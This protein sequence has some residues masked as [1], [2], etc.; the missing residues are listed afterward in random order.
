MSNMSRHVTREAE[1]YVR[2]RMTN[3]VVIALEG[4]RYFEQTRSKRNGIGEARGFRLFAG[5]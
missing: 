4:E 5:N 2:H 1:T 3:D